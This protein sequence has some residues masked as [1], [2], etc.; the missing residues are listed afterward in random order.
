MQ[1]DSCMLP[2]DL[3]AGYRGSFGERWGFPGSRLKLHPQGLC[4]DLFLDEGAHALQDHKSG[5][6]AQKG[7]FVL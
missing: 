6:S 5:S 7:A 2:I 1:S 4:F 3:F